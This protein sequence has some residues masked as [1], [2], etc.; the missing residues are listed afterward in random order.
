MD[1]PVLPRQESPSPKSYGTAVALSSVLGFI[2]GH[3]F[4]LRGWAEGVLDAALSV[5]WPQRV[6][7]EHDIPF[8]AAARCF[9]TALQSRFFGSTSL[10]VAY[11]S[12]S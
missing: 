3:H 2:G 11:S 8:A 9:R 5:T 6:A 1:S 12:T 7:V 10:N 4:H